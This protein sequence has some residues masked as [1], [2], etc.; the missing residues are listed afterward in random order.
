[1]MKLPFTGKPKVIDLTDLNLFPELL[2]EYK[3]ICAE[4]EKQMFLFHYMKERQGNDLIITF[5]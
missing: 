4:E 2:S 3:S 1:M 5:N